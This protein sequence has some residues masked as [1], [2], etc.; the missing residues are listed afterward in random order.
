M[1][2]QIKFQTACRKQNHKISFQFFAIPLVPPRRFKR[3]GK[4]I[5]GFVCA[6]GRIVPEAR[7]VRFTRQSE[8]TI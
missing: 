4:E 8:R 2:F 1:N 5:F 6:T 3:K 7:I